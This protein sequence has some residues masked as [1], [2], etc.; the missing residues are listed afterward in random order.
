MD[1]YLRVPLSEDGKRAGELAVNIAKLFG[2]N[3]LLV[4]VHPKRLEDAQ[5]DGTQQSREIGEPLREAEMD[6]EAR[7]DGLEGILG[8]RPQTEIRTAEGDPAVAILEAAQEGDEPTLIAVGSRGL[9]MI[10]RVRLGSVS[11]KVLRAATGAGL[12]YPRS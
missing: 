5:E 1:R 2:A 7:A 4:R 6:L 12:V 8:R 11:T 10:Q 9:G 3:A